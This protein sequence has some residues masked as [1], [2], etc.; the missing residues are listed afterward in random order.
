[1][2]TRQTQSTEETTQSWYKLPA[3]GKLTSEDILNHYS[4]VFKA[5][6]GKPLE[7][8]MHIDLD[9]S[10]TPVHAPRRRVPVAELESMRNLKGS[11]KKEL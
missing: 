1:M 3:L 7:S 11:A 10:V 9:P 5:G 8:P 4:N 2:Q 6:R